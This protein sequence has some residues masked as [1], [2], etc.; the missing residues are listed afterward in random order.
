MIIGAEHQK[1]SWL[2]DKKENINF[3]QKCTYREFDLVKNLGLSENIEKKDLAFKFNSLN[4]KHN[5]SKKSNL[6]SIHVGASRQNKIAPDTFWV[7]LLS[8]LC[9]HK[10]YEIIIIGLKNEISGIQ[11]LFSRATDVKNVSFI[12]GSLSKCVNIIANSRLVVTMDSGFGHI[13]SSIGTKHL[14]IFSSYAPEIVAPI[15]PNTIF[16]SQKE[17]CQPCQS[18]KCQ[19][20]ENY[21]LTNLTPN[22]VL[23]QIIEALE[24]Q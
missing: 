14:C 11:K 1:N 3:F 5:S 23:C 8:K 2:F 20:Q 12:S 4:N 22:T 24:D 16:I 7:E 15:Y 21:C 17:Y 19:R 9:N 6:I 10:N 13:A 18:H